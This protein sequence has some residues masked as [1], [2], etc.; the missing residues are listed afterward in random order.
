M[1]NE[2]RNFRAGLAQNDRN[3]AAY[4]IL[5]WEIIIWSIVGALAVGYHFDSDRVTLISFC[6][7]LVVLVVGINIPDLKIIILIFFGL[8]WA[9][10]FILLGAWL[11]RFFYVI[12]FFTFLMSF[13]IH[14]WG[15]TYL[16]DLTRS[17]ND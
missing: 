17:D 14:Y 16:K 13:F 1:A 10:P 2:I 9:S 7:L 12:A 11:D 15:M 8:G 6:T 5:I 4:N 3:K